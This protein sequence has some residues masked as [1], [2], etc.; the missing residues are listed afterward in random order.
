MQF[1]SKRSKYPDIPYHIILCPES[2]FATVCEIDNI[3][4]RQ[5]SATHAYLLIFKYTP[6]FVEWLTSLANLPLLIPFGMGSLEKELFAL[7]RRQNVTWM[8]IV[9]SILSYGSKS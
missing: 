4:K 2:P 5:K 9:A 1:P 6:A 7:P 8:Q 3:Q